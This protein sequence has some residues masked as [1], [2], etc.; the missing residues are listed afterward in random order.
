M[1]NYPRYAIYYVPAP[2]SDL[3]RFGAAM[4]GYDAASGDD[5]PFPAG[6]VRAE[7]DWQDLTSDPRKYGFH[8]TLKAPFS[9]AP[10]RTETELLAACAAFA[11]TPRA[12]PVIRPVVG[13]ISGFI[14]V[15]P[16]DPPAELI[17]L[18]ADCVSEFDTFRAPLTETDRARRNPSRLTSA[19][20]AY[21]D[22]WGY[23][24][25]MEEFR[26]HMTLTGRL[27][28]NRLETVMTM[29]RGSFSTLG[30]ETLAID[31]LAL[32]RQDAA[33]SRFRIARQYV[34]MP[35]QG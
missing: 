28:A 21:L 20:R 10:C 32:F 3:H 6:V 34:L 2:A 35:G 24:Y 13:S 9:L 22:R 7:P 14:A 8:A 23:P 29:L 5:V 19:Q 25:V 16:A 33:D 26:F 30:L 17:R 4:L 12:I 15:I 18:A 1:S 27:D 31:R 11:A